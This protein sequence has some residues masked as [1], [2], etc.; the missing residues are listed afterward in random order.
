LDRWIWEKVIKE[1]DLL[2]SYH[3]NVRHEVIR[4][5]GLILTSYRIEVTIDEVL[6]AYLK[7]VGK[8]EDFNPQSKVNQSDEQDLKNGALKIILLLA[9]KLLKDENYGYKSC[10]EWLV[11]Y[12][13]KVVNLRGTPTDQGVETVCRRFLRQIVSTIVVDEQEQMDYFSLLQRNSKYNVE[14]VLNLLP[15]FTWMNVFLISQAVIQKQL[16]FAWKYLETEQTSENT[17]FIRKAAAKLIAALFQMG[18]VSIKTIQK[19]LT[20]LQNKHGKVCILTSLILTEPYDVPKWLPTIFVQLSFYAGDKTVAIKSEIQDCL[21]EFKRTH[22]V[23]W[24]V[25]YK[26]KFNE[27]QLEAFYELGEPPSYFA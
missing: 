15:L 21:K 1:K 16:K 8:L 17:K 3:A 20:K 14:M 6:E 10:F 12:C 2:S 11:P 25:V 13:L 23:G 18:H 7:V 26:P 27:E 24:D 5:V 4:I 22:T 9:T 19:K